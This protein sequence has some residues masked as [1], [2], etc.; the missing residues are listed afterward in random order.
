[1]ISVKLPLHSRHYNQAFDFR[2][3]QRGN[4]KKLTIISVFEKDD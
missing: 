3:K 1:M 2:F 4:K